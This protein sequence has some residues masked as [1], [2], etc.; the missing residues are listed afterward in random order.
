MIIDTKKDANEYFDHNQKEKYIYI[1]LIPHN[2]MV[3]YNGD[4]DI[5]KTE[6][7]P[8]FEE[9]NKKCGC[10]C[11]DDNCKLNYNYNQSILVE[12]IVDL[13]NDYGSKGVK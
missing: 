4:L 12:K 11:E 6:E 10:G 1:A 5:I 7:N 9:D 3:E 2:E 13:I 8:N